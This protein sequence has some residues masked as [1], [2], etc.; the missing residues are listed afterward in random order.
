MKARLEQELKDLEKALKSKLITINEY[1]EA[2][3]AIN[4]K[5]RNLK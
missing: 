3:F 4:Q 2:R 1:C 5:I